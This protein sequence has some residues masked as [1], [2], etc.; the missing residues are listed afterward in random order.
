MDESKKNAI[1]VIAGVSAFLS[2]MTANEAQLYI[3]IIVGLLA[4]A[5][6]LMRIYDF[7][8]N[9]KKGD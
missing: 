9:G 2:A 7:I 6:Y 3:N 8:F 1:D 5:W 4:A